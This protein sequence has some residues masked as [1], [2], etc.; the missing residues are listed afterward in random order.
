MIG[1]LDE[2]ENITSEGCMKALAYFSIQFNKNINFIQVSICP[3][4]LLLPWNKKLE[5]ST[6]NEKHSKYILS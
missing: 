2:M 3:I 6:N 1:K 4:Y 5:K